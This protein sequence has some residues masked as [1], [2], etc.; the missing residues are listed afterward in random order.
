VPTATQR[1]PRGRFGSCL[2]TGLSV[3]LVAAVIFAVTYAMRVDACD[4]QDSSTGALAF[5]AGFDVI[6]AAAVIALT[7]KR[8]RGAPIAAT[9]GWVASFLPVAAV[10]SVGV[11]YANTLPHSCA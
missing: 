7:R 4:E 11:A 2:M 8:N 3:H 6:L 1:R 5:A 9:L 10:F